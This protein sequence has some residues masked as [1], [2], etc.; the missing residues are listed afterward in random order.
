MTKKR[1][2]D[3]ERESGGKKQKKYRTIE[4]QRQ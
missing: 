3:K 1:E 4:K 2:R